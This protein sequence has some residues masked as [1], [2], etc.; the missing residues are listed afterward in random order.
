MNMAWP[1]APFSWRTGLKSSFNLLVII[2]LVGAS[3]LSVGCQ[4][5]EPPPEA[6]LVRSGTGAYTLGESLELTFTKP[7]EAETLEVVLWPSARGTRRVP[8]GEVDSLLGPCSVGA[9]C[10]GLTIAV[11]ESGEGATLELDDTLAGPGANFILEVLPGLQDRAGNVTGTSYLYNIR[12]RATAGDPNA[13]IAFDNGIFILGGAVNHPMRAV[14]TLVTDIKVLPD[15]RFVM[16][17]ARGLVQEGENDTTRDPT[18]ITVDDS[19]NGWTLFANGLVV[20]NEAGDRFLETEAFDVA[21]PVL[22]GSLFLELK[23]VRLFA[24][25]VKDDRGYDFVDGTLSY[26]EIILINTGTGNSTTYDGDNAELLGDFVI[27][28]EI[29]VGSPDMC[30]EICGAV[31]GICE[32]PEGFPGEGFCGE[33]VEA[34]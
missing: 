7:V 22:G 34:E 16:V 6:E 33:D 28:E 25:F 10:E 27:T 30:G 31:T 18:V 29:P 2:A 20:E 23:E 11:D 5:Y 15:G 12:F 13:N 17:G 8:E 14:L 1:L 24:D 19:E 26:E 4:E 32:P 9:S 21:I 3:F